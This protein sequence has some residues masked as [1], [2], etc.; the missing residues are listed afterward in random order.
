MVDYRVN[1]DIFAGPLDLLLYLV[2]KEEVDIYDIPIAKIT[3]QYIHYI[4]MLKSL[5]IDLAG[6]FL[7]MAATLMQIK[8]AMLLPKAEPEQMQADELDDPRAEL[9]RQ[10]LEY[11][12]FKDAANLLS[13]AAASQSERFPRPESVIE[14]INPEPEPQ[15]DIE[16]VSVWDLLEAFASLMQATGADRAIRHIKDDTPIDLYQIEILHRLQEEGPMSFERIFESKPN[17]VVMIGLFLALLELIREKLVFAKQIAALSSIY[18]RP[19]TDEPAEKAVQKAIIALSQPEKAELGQIQ[20]RK[21]PPIPI[22]EI[23]TKSKSG[24]TAEK[25]REEQVG[26]TKDG[27]QQ[28]GD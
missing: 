13:D 2:R 17:R 4:E 20:E 23:P 7:V 25:L 9:I 21:Q 10:L 5:D 11:K 15:I 1:L 18:L 22:V 16:S 3:D 8:S 14:S 12:K 28:A 26:L 19:L 24:I 27:G 6:D